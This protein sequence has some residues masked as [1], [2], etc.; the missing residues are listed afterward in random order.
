LGCRFIQC[1]IEALTAKPRCLGTP[2]HSF[3]VGDIAEG[4]GNAGNIVR[5][6]IQAGIK[7]C[8][9]VLG[10]TQVSR[11]VIVRR[12]GPGGLLAGAGDHALIYRTFAQTGW[13]GQCRWLASTSLR[14]CARG[15]GRRSAAFIHASTVNSGTPF[16][17]FRCESGLP[18]SERA[19]RINERARPPRYLRLSIQS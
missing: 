2:A 3:R 19:T 14:R 10:R 8:G 9:Q 1:P 5:G 17:T 12:P 13:L 11:D 15:E 18:R 16:G 6:I 4:A 7:V